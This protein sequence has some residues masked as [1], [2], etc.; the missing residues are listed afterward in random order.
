MARSKKRSRKSS[1]SSSSSKKQGITYK[2]VGVDTAKIGRIHSIIGSMIAGTHGE[3]VISGYGHYAGLISI[4]DERVLAMHID[5]VGSKVIV[6]S[7]AGKYSTIGID[8]IAMNAND[9]VCVGAEPIAFVDYIAVRSPDADMIEEIMKGLAQGAREANLSIVGGELAVLPDLLADGFEM[10]KGK[11]KATRGRGKVKD[12]MDNNAFDLAGAVIGIARK[13]ELILG[14]SINAGDVIVGIASN[15]LHA[16]GYTLAR[17]VLLSRYRLD[18]RI[19]ELDSTL[20]DELLKPTRIYV[21]PILDVIKRIDVHGIA[22]ITGGAFKK[23]TRLNSSVKFVLDSMP[24]PPAIFRLIK[25]HAGIDDA[26][27]YSTFNMG[28]GMC[29]VAA[30]GD[31]DAIISICKSHDMDAMV[32]GRVEEGNGVYINDVRIA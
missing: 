25:M 26:E 12:R 24:E 32:I 4:D 18:E 17:H 22:H 23:L 10:S 11:G 29:V 6:A 9:V 1:I 8:C 16:N 14:E 27:M 15:G 21:K 19:D 20:E 28:I 5:G 30:R 31:E 2:D 13:D 7:L 3:H